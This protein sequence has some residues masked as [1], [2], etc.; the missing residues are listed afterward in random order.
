MFNVALG[1]CLSIVVD[2]T[3]RSRDCVGQARCVNDGRDSGC[4]RL[5]AEAGRCEVAGGGHVGRRVGGH[6]VRR[7]VNSS[8]D[9]IHGSRRVSGVSAVASWASLSDGE[10]LGLVLNNG[11]VDGNRRRVHR[12]GRGRSS[13]RRNDRLGDDRS[14]GREAAGGGGL[15]NGRA[16]AHA[17]IN[18]DCL[19]NGLCWSGRR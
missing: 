16:A 5:G 2:W 7:R 9:R 13:D 15:S 19:S 1:N 17:R 11:V 12:R 6:R 14:T 18:D 10:G 4:W 8:R 3:G